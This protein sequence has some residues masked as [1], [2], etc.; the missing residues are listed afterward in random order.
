M[1]RPRISPEV[2]EP[3]ESDLER[4]GNLL[5]RIGG[6]NVVW[7]ARE[8]L[9]IWVIEQRA[10]LDQEMSERIRTASWVLAAGTF[11]LVICT[12]ALVWVTR[13]R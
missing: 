1:K 6:Q 8:L 5:R 7:G 3:N 12:A 13:T 2:P 10:K 9:D 11:G 4:I